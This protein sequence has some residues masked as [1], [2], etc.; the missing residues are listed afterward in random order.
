MKERGLYEVDPK[1]NLQLK[2]PRATMRTFTEEYNRWKRGGKPYVVSTMNLSLLD[3]A[4][5]EWQAPLLAYYLKSVLDRIGKLVFQEI[6][7]D[8]KS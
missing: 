3:P 7:N 5:H 4:I 2:H 1:D 8:P 6:P